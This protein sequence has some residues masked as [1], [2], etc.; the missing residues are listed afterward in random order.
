MSVY[1]PC[2]LTWSPAG[3][4]NGVNHTEGLGIGMT[5]MKLSGRES[6]DNPDV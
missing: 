2:V 5:L 4:A 3:L 1:Q 6:R